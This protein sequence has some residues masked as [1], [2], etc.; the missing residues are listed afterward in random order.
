MVKPFPVGD[1]S[2]LTPELSLG[3]D[4][5]GVDCAGAKVQVIDARVGTSV[6]T[7]VIPRSAATFSDGQA[8]FVHA[9]PAPK[10]LH[11]LQALDPVSFPD[12][13]LCTTS[14]SLRVQIVF[15]LFH[16]ASVS[17]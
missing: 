15:S 9:R 1:P 14:P 7:G 10:H 5:L 6:G 17:A 12:H 2:I 13:P 4:T 16:L 3:A 11:S 8:I